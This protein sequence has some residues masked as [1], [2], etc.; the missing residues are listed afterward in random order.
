MNN[1]NKL[2]Q[3]FTSLIILHKLNI[4]I[5]SSDDQVLLAGYQIPIKKSINVELIN[6][7]TN[8][9]KRIN[10][11]DINSDVYQYVISKRHTLHFIILIKH[12]IDAVDYVS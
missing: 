1:F 3:Y 11:Y 2:I 5:M 9:C 12:E 7:I 4:P 8:Q 6:Y 10:N